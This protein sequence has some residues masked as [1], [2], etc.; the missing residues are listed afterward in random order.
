MYYKLHKISL[1]RGI[2]HID[3]PKWLTNKK[4]TINPKNNDD[5]CFQY[6]VTVA[7]IHEQI[8]SHPERISNIKTFTDQYKWKE[9][10]FSSHK[11]VWNEFEKK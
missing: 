8:K 5:K 3:S 4:A 6:A 7:L 11:K 9:I 1:N 2:S 10:D